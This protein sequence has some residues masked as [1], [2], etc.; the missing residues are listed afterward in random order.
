MKVALVSDCYLP[1][2][3]GVVSAI[4]ELDQGLAGRGHQP[5]IWAS[6]T[7]GADFDS[8]NVQRW[9]AL[10][11]RP[12]MSLYSGIASPVQM[13]RVLS[14]EG[15]DLV[16]C[17][18]EFGLGWAAKQA[19]RSLGLPLIHTMHTMYEFYRHYLPGLP[20]AIPRTLLRR[21]LRGIDAI[22]C[23]STRARDYLQ[24]LDATLP[25][26][27]IPNGVNSDRFRP[28]LLSEELRTQGRAAFGIQPG[29][30]LIL[31]VGR[32]WHEKRVK[33]LLETL[34][35]LLQKHAD[36]HLMIVGDGPDR[37][38][39]FEMAARAGI[40]ARLTLPGFV[41][42]D[43]MPGIYAL[44]DVYI[45]ASLSEVHPLSLIEASLSGLPVLARQDE[46]CTTVVEEGIGGHLCASDEEL[47]VALTALVADETRRAALATGARRSGLRFRAETHLDRIETIY[48]QTL[49]EKE[50]RNHA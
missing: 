4:M 10:P 30:R 17:H 33:P 15:V 38:T 8:S 37:T 11:F 49:D 47:A 14:A 21:Y 32:L 50:R 44:A 39:L 19:A 18:T 40:E 27:V 16:H 1:T 29:K 2:R 24:A 36:W 26:H 3:N 35:P 31:A 28:D 20:L 41:Q 13:R 5:L 12:Q 25:L 43:H 45:S 42:Q 6:R 46:G 9:P 22:I 23:P 7:P 48:R 34:I